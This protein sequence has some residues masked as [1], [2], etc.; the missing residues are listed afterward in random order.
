[1]RQY[2][3]RRFLQSIPTLLLLTII[4]FGF[5][6]L[7][8]GDFVDAMIDPTALTSNSEQVLAQQRVALG[9]DQPVVIQYVNWVGQLVQGNLGYSF[10]YK[11]PVLGMIAERLW[12]TIQLGGAAIIVA[13]IAGVSAGVVS[14]LRPYSKFDYIV[15][16]LSY[17]AWSFP[18]F[19]LGLIL[20][21]IFAV[22]LKILPSAGMLTPGVED[23]GDR[24]KHL[25]L[26]VTALCVQFIGQF[27]RQT[28]S[29]VLEVR[30]EEYVN[31]ARAKGLRPRRI[32]M[33]HILPNA[34]IPIITVI[35]LSLPIL[36]TGAIVTEMVFSWS[37][38]GTLMINAI[39]ARD[40]P[41]VMGTVLV[42]GIVVLSVNLIIDMLYAVVDPRI[43]YA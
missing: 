29:A 14:G 6:Q 26:P 24:L 38:M 30:G 41:V 32:T 8:P 17:G 34:L 35:G 37:G 7:A 42:I 18:N 28:R 11:R 31:T 20:I 36:I 15:S 13:A 1:M 4:T 39:T 3:F 33:R 21:Y 43:R 23:F 25:I 16:I 27:A 9:L 2:I 22:Q 12:A 19:Y 5:M 40:Y 10:V